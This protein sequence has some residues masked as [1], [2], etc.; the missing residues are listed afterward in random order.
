[1]VAD[2]PRLELTLG[3]LVKTLVSVCKS[4]TLCTTLPLREDEDGMHRFGPESDSTVEKW[5]KFGKEYPFGNF[6][7]LTILVVPSISLTIFTV[8]TLVSYLL[9][10][11]GEPYMLL[12]N[13]AVH[14]RNIGGNAKVFNI[15][16]VSGGI[17]LF[18]EQA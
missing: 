12:A 7:Y 13:N 11:I 3:E 9:N 4:G 17:P 2:A 1:M 5:Q 15:S 10:D 6:C 14:S 16:T 8:G 18:A